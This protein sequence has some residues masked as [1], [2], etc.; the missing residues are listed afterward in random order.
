MHMLVGPF[1]SLTFLEVAARQSY[2][3][4]VFAFSGG[5]LLE[6]TQVFRQLL[7]V[8]PNRRSQVPQSWHHTA[9]LS[10]CHAEIQ[11]F[12]W[13]ESDHSKR[14]GIHALQKDILNVLQPCGNL[15]P[16]QHMQ[17]LVSVEKIISLRGSIVCMRICE[18]E[19]TVFFQFCILARDIYRRCWPC[20]Y[21]NISPS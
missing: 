14:W 6:R 10:L 11:E 9:T 3:P 18:V 4:R 8:F 21:H 16:F 5:F 2:H 1:Q 13:L 17:S 7:T 12:E 20:H 15:I 19:G